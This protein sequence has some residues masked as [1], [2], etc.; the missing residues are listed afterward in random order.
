MS[1]SI[2]Q[3]ERKCLICGE[4]NN[5]HRHHIFFGTANRRKSELFGCWC[6][7]CAGHHNA[8]DFGVH[9]DRHFDLEL[10]QL[11]QEKWEETYGTRE[12][13]IQEFGRNYL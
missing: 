9:F 12:E 4:I 8:T 11:C 10:K 5:L 6:F 1:K 13:F 2:M 7:L 3:E